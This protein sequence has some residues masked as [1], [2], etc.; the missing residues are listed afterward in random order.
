MEELSGR[1]RSIAAIGGGP[2]SCGVTPRRVLNLSCMSL[3][4]T[5]MDECEII[6]Q[7]FVG[8]MPMT[9]V[10]CMVAFNLQFPIK[11][12]DK[13]RYRSSHGSFEM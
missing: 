4:V 9:D 7:F 12:N 11:I 5:R 8:L 13:C 6:H 1:W 10:I 3:R 2:E